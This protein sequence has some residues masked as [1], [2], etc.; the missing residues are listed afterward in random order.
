MCCL[1]GM[2][3]VVVSLFFISDPAAGRSP[4]H[5]EYSGTM[6]QSRLGTDRHIQVRWIG[7]AFALVQAIFFVVV[8]FLGTKQRGPLVALFGLGGLVYAAAFIALV[9]VE[10]T[11]AQ[12]SAQNMILGFPLP[13]AIMVYGVGGTPIFFS[14]VYVLQFDRWVMKSR[15]LERISQLAN[16]R[17][18]AEAGGSH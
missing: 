16:E 9:L 18:Q 15:D 6:Y 13:T 10:S 17:R 1:V 5:A 7:L 3:L 11:Y 8:L 4:A 14:V 12:G 2:C